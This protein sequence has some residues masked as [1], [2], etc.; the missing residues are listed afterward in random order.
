M[1]ILCPSKTFLL[2]EYAVLDG[3]PALLIATEPNFTYENH[4][5]SDPYQGQGGFGASGAKFIFQHYDECRSA[6]SALKKYHALHQLGSG[7]DIVCQYTGGLTY[8]FPRKKIIEKFVWPF[9]DLNIALIH[10]GYKINTHEHLAEVK[11][12]TQDY[13]ILENIVKMAYQALLD[14][15]DYQFVQFI[16]AYQDELADLKLSCNNTLELLDKIKKHNKILAAKGCGALGADVLLIILDKK[17][18]QHFLQWSKKENL[19][20][21]YCDNQFTQGVRAV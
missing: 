6:Q 5:F 20:V 9:D 11:Q 19:T 4:T 1:K 17:Y 7:A 10:T 16:Q 18:T 8:F 21:V 2:G 13:S 3:G 14:G 15:D 12:S